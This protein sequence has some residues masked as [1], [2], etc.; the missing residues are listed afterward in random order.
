MWLSCFVHAKDLAHNE[1]RIISGPS[2]LASRPRLDIYQEPYEMVQNDTK[3]PWHGRF[4]QAPAEATRQ[5]VESLS[6]DNRLWKHDIAGS[7]AHAR[8]LRKV[9][10]IGQE[11]LAAIEKGLDSIAKDIEQGRFQ[12]N[13]ADEDV[14]MAI[15]AALTARIGEPA[16]RLHTARSRNDQIALDLRLWMREMIDGTTVPAM[17]R[18]Q[19]A[20]VRMAERQGTAVMPGYTHMQRAQPVLLGAYL[21]SFVEGFERDVGRFEDLRKRV[22]ISPLGS[23]ALAGS[24][25]PIE[26]DAVAADL[27]FTG[28]TAS[29]IDAVSDRDPAVEYVFACSLLSARLSRLAEDWVLF[30]SQE[31]QFLRIDDAYCT[32]SSMMP[33]KRNPDLLELIR[34]RTG[35]AYGALVGLMTIVKGLPTGYNRDLQE[36]KFHLFAA[37]DSALL[38]LDVAAEVIDHSQFGEDK[39]LAACQGGFLDATAL[40][41]YLVNKKMPF[42]QAHQI[43]GQLVAQCEKRSCELRDLPL[44]ELRSA[45]PLIS[46]DVYDWLG[47]QN[48]VSR[49][50]SKGSAGSVSFNESLAAWKTRL[51]I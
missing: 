33:Q 21:L 31:F 19:A 3:P 8:M 32:G 38:C 5:F 14:H 26:P 28:V 40:A 10:L 48:V 41:E 12:W 51:N 24:T 47:P 22:N 13:P 6:A 15:E 20:L 30:C 23:G 35:R 4:T 46:K 45:T 43:V 17:R 16:K 29:S 49:Y 36:D 11:D 42:R 1:P 7:I 27:G 39:L 50:V 9:G 25:L 2:S 34:A 18:L 44:E 37:H